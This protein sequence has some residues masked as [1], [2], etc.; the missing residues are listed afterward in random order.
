MG[1]H[2][3]PSSSWLEH[4]ARMSDESDTPQKDESRRGERRVLRVVS[5]LIGIA[6]IAAG[7]SLIA[8]AAGFNLLRLAEPSW[9]VFLAGVFILPIG[10]IFLGSA[11]GLLGERG[12]RRLF[13]VIGLLTL[14]LMHRV[15]LFGQSRGG[16]AIGPFTFLGGETNAGA[17]IVL[18]LIDGFIAVVLLTKFLPT[19]HHRLAP[20]DSVTKNRLLWLGASVIFFALFL[21][22]E[23]IG[24][25]GPH[26]K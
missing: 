11:T 20:G 15:A 5:S 8:S 14:V 26:S 4:G 22:G 23:A 24:L 17:Y 19:L 9:V 16:V 3:E 7:L 6:A 18:S 10:C 21:A 1:S 12:F 2:V 25:Y 13:A